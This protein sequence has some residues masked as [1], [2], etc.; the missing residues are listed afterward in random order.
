MVSTSNISHSQSV[1]HIKHRSLLLCFCSTTVL[2]AESVRVYT[3]EGNT[4]HSGARKLE[5]VETSLCSR[6]TFARG[7]SEQQPLTA[8][9]TTTARWLQHTYSFHVTGISLFQYSTP[10]NHRNDRKE[11]GVLEA[12]AQLPETYTDV[13]PLELI[14]NNHIYGYCF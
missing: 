14:K 9:T 4:V 2:L 3:K 11:H 8:L 5:V 13:H 12:V 1:V 6:P 10:H 7:Y